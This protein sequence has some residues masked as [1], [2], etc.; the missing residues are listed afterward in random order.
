MAGL[1][2][3]IH[4]SCA[5]LLIMMLVSLDS[6]VRRGYDNERWA[7]TR[8]CHRQVKA[9]G[10][11]RRRARVDYIDG[12][13]MVCCPAGARMAMVRTCAASETAIVRI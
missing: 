7:A 3:V 5:K 10:A 1:D 12:K 6:R 2:P 9:F 11:W 8:I 13:L 4:Q